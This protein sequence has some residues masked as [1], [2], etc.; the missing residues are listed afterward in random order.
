MDKKGKDMYKKIVK[1]LYRSFDDDLNQKEKKQLAEALKNSEELRQE[2][3]Q[4][5]AQRQV[6]SKSA[7]RS[8]KPFFAERVMS[9]I[10][11]L[12]EKESSVDV[13]YESFKAVFR[14]VAIAG[15]VILLALFIYNL[16]IGE[17]L[18]A[19]EAFYAVDVTM[20]EVLQLPL[21]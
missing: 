2:K 16:G 6:V 20:E 17:I 11:T 3:E 8:F 21:F 7:T 12:G 4:I 19:E 15:A 18:S 1:L 14:H 10:K 5:L 13:F 9:R